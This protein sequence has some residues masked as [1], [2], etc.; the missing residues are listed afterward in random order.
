[1]IWLEFSCIF[2][3]FHHFKGKKSE[4]QPKG[5]NFSHLYEIS[6]ENLE[7]YWSFHIIF[8]NAFKCI[9]CFSE[10]RIGCFMDLDIYTQNTIWKF[11]FEISVLMMN[12]IWAGFPIQR[13]ASDDSREPPAGLPARFE[14]NLILKNPFC[15]DRLFFDEKYLKNIK[16]YWRNERSEWSLFC[17]IFWRI[18]WRLGKSGRNLVNDWNLKNLVSES[19][20]FWDFFGCLV[21]FYYVNS[22]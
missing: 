10:K 1:M 20:E 13:I 17:A 7:F 21:T 12:F 2:S 22:R 6:Y 5:C 9:R 4:F 16:Q 14:A 15:F 18:F 11:E 8:K 3:Q 19:Q